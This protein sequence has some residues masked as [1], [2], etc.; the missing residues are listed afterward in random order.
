MYALVVM[1]VSYLIEKH[2]SSTGIFTKIWSKASMPSIST[3]FAA[4]Y[5]RISHAVWQKK[6]IRSIR[7][8][9][10]EKLALFL[11]DKMVLLRKE[12]SAKTDQ[13]QKNLV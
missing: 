10:E 13:K 6:S 9:E 1:L 8:D 4:L 11:N 12:I 2:W 3:Y 7:V 5:Y